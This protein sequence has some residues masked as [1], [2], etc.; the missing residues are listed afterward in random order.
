MY[1]PVVGGVFVCGG[2]KLESMSKRLLSLIISLTLNSLG[3]RLR[4]AR[5]AGSTGS[6]GLVSSGLVRVWV[7]G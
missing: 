6:L 5:A 2:V 1:E 3:S 4:W 7:C